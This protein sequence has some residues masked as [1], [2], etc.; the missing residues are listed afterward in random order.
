MLKLIDASG[1]KDS[2][3][4]RRANLTKQH[5]SKI[6]SN[7]DYRPTKPTA[8]ALAIALELDLDQTKDLLGRAGFA[9]SNASKFDVIVS[10]FISRRRY[11]MFEIN[12][13]LFEFDQLTLGAS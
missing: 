1:K 5:F 6:R 3:I 7:P 4:Y 11:D 13:A 8:V 2:E 9:L 10:Y 12:A